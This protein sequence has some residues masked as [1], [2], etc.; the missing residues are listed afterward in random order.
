MTKKDDNNYNRHVIVNKIIVYHNELIIINIYS[1]IMV[2]CDY[3]ML[4]SVC[5]NAHAYPRSK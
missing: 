4:C 2:G 3:K 1:L 5:Y